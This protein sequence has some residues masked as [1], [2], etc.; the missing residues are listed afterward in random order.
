MSIPV[1]ILGPSGAGKT[2]SL[3]NLPKDSYGLIECE[4][5]MLPFRGGKRF[6]R[7]KDF[8]GL[9]GNVKRYAEKYG[10]EIQK[11]EQDGK[12]KKEKANLRIKI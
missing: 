8:A 9:R 12:N 2:Y 3:R 7:T 11:N 10:V 1:L 6:A 5:T 4:K